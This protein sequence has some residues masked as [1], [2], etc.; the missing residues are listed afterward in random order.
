MVGV[1]S[2]VRASGRTGEPPPVRPLDAKSPGAGKPGAP[3]PQCPISVPARSFVVRCSALNCAR[4]GAKPQKEKTVYVAFETAAGSVSKPNEDFVAASPS[5]AIVLDGLSAPPALSTGCTHGTPWYVARLGSELLSSASTE[6]DQPLQEV[7]AGA[8]TSVVDLHGHTCDLDDPG[9]PASS[10][11]IV[12]EG[13]QGLD[14]LVLFDSVIVL[15]GPSDL[16]VVTDRRVDAF[17]QAEESAIREHPIGSPAHQARVD[18]LVTAQRRHR[19]QPGGYWVAGAKPAAAYE[20]VAGSLPRSLITRAALL[21]DGVSCLVERYGAGDWS[22]LL[23]VLQDEGPGRLIARA[24][25]LEGS[26]P[27]G[28]RRPR[29]KAG[30]DATAAICLPSWTSHPGS[31]TTLSPDPARRTRSPP[32]RPAPSTARPPVRRRHRWRPA[33]AAEPPPPPDRL[34]GTAP[35]R[36]ETGSTRSAR[37]AREPTPDTAR[38]P[39]PTAAG[40]GRRS[41]RPRS[42]RSPRPRTGPW[43]ADRRSRR[44]PRRSGRCR[45]SAPAAPAHRTR[46]PPGRPGPSTAPRPGPHR[47]A[48]HRAR[49]GARPAPPAGPP[50]WW[51]DRGARGRSPSRGPGRRRHRRRR[52]RGPARRSPRVRRWSP[53]APR[54]RSPSRARPPRTGRAPRHRGPSHSPEQV[55]TPSADPIPRRPD[56]MNLPEGP[57]ETKGHVPSAVASRPRPAARGTGGATSRARPPGRP[58]SD[59]R[60]ARP[61]SAPR[62]SAR[63]PRRRRPPPRRTAPGSAGPAPG[64]AREWRPG[65]PGTSGCARSGRG[66]RRPAPWSGRPAPGCPPPRPRS[67]RTRAPARRPRP[68]AAPPRRPATAATIR[69]G[70][71]PPSRS[72]TRAPPRP[73]PRAPARR[74]PRCRRRPQPC[75]WVQ[76]T[77]V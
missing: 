70:R 35:G 7:L 71:W 17:A 9:T 63:R 21:S 42:S 23:T 75:P 45:G 3:Q 41:P 5:V 2:P 53:L 46:C 69:A 39:W 18:Q 8:I 59:R 28:A 58:G 77:S 56:A 48:S 19:N 32:D 60:T 10:V 30:D 40:H 61:G 4:V 15:E 62:T 64:P 11:T 29:Y 67:G 22:W 47:R 38:H 52:R 68:P 12:R 24:R 43:P 31:T 54:W 73:P 76:P 34:P 37:R 66:R 20:A 72:A 13:D 74:T 50:R 14:Y 16:K 1:S 26:D 6:P 33:P 36:D 44:P 27:S 55:A 25:E 51:R 65:R 57:G 49:S